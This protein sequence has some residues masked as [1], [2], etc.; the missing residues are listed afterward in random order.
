MTIV[1]LDQSLR[2]TTDRVVIPTDGL[3]II[4]ELDQ[5]AAVTP[6]QGCPVADGGPSCNH[7]CG[8]GWPNTEHSTSELTFLVYTHAVNPK[9]LGCQPLVD[10]ATQGALVVQ[11]EEAALA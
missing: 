11:Q 8:G 6:V 2:P 9:K 1:E 5:S 10:N 4:I 3:P 7:L